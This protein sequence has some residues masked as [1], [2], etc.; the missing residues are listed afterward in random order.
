MPQNI[1]DPWTRDLLKF[2]TY[3]D[4]ETWQD[5]L[6]EIKTMFVNDQ[7][8]KCFNTDRGKDWLREEQLIRPP[9]DCGVVYSFSSKSK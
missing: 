1:L 9:G 3:R 5:K 6:V 4:W 7:V 8:L 2:Y